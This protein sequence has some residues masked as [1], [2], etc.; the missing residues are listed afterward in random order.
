MKLTIPFDRIDESVRS[1]VG[2]KALALARMAHGGMA[3]PPGLA[4]TTAAYGRYVRATGLRERI[5][6][7]LSR[8]PF[9]EMRW[10]E[11]WDAALRIRNM[12]L[13][14]PIPDELAD[15]LREGIDAVVGEQPVAVRSSAPGEDAAEASFAG[16][17]ESYVNV[18][19]SEA[20]VEHVRL[21]WASLWS[22]RAL[23]YR[24][25]LGLD[26]QH[27]TMAVVV[28][29]LVAGE[30]S[31]VVFGRSPTEPAQ[32]IVEAVHGLNQGLVDGTVEPDRWV[33]ERATG[34]LVSHRAADRE[35]AV[36]PGESGVRLAPLAPEVRRRPPLEDDE[37]ARVFALARAAEDRF[38]SPQDVEWTM[39]A[40]AL[41]ALQ[42][43]PIT[44]AAPAE[45]DDK[46]AWYLSLTRSFENLKQLRRTIEDELVPA[47]DAEAARLAQAALDALTDAELADEIDSRDRIHQKWKQVYW[48]DF[49][50]FAHG[51]RLF[52]QVYNDVV[53][54]ADPFEFTRLLG[55]TRMTSLERNRE[56]EA[57]AGQVRES[58]ALAERLGAGE[59]PESGAFTQALD[60][61]L[62]RYSI[63]PQDGATGREALVR[64]LVQM[65]SRPPARERLGASDIEALRKDFL[66]R[67]E[68][69]E[70]RRA[71][72]L[73]DLARASYEWRDNDNIHLRAIEDEW[74]R[75]RAEGQRRLVG[76][77]GHQAGSAP[78][79][80]V[81][82]LL[83]DPS[84]PVAHEAAMR[85]D[86][87]PAGVQPRQLLGQPAGPG[88]ATG[89]ARV[90]RDPSQVFDV[91]A[92]EIL[93]CDAI[94]PNMTFVVP[95]SAG[96][97]ERRGGMLI[98]GA[99]IAREY[100]LPCVTG[101]PQATERIETGMRLTVD[102]YLGIVTVRATR[103]CGAEARAGAGGDTT[104]G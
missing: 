92:G 81:A 40:D 1:A 5:L 83:R 41:F 95:L 75:A 7:E 32:A 17:H 47:M 89:T 73:L 35:Q 52:G 97:V 12:F 59:E 44:S 77:H 93:V 103:G 20:I 61:F 34:R 100:G 10:E 56:L 87:T 58:P 60:R 3:V 42:S 86:A 78:P 50:P 98:H 21:V 69:D 90:I 62:D 19:G 54:P 82:T 51:A 53:R 71:D 14:T 30:R 8:K 11:M 26:V 22:D 94:D 80:A 2:G 84:H 57:L 55:A 48:D 18:S 31:G 37:V 68:Q 96:I 6:L 15:A 70:R 43:R 38:G 102:G 24:H 27:S 76:H 45:G 39:R 13:T 64:L 67:F 28:Q 88:I 36:L 99:I 72:E 23:L 65:A 66:A 46:R 74:H 85:Q 25:E 91:Q 29:E 33:L 79:E 101:V 104:A 63:L 4:V 9:E 16:L 49:I